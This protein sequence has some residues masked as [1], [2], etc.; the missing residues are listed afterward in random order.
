MLRRV[1]Q[2]TGRRRVD[3]LPQLWER[4]LRFGSRSRLLAAALLATLAAGQGLADVVHLLD[5]DRISGQVVSRRK[6]TLVVK[7]SF[8]SLTIPRAKIARIVR[9]D[10]SQE[11]LNAPAAPAAT[12]APPPPVR[13]VL[14]VTGQ[15][16]WYAWAPPKGVA[17]DP[18]LRLMVSLDEATI[19][20][21]TDAT[22]DPRDLPSALVNSFS[23][24]PDVVTLS[25]SGEAQVASPESRPGR[26]VLK[27]DLP[28]QMNRRHR[29]RLA[30]Q[31]NDG[32]EEEPAW[33]DCAE[34]A[35][36]IALR[37]DAPNFVHISQNRGEME[38]SGLL[39]RKMKRVES[40]RIQARPE[41]SLEEA[42][43]PS[44]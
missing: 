20:T 18:T 42:A 33:R 34:T 43:P 19:A 35:L 3:A 6:T 1:F 36:E 44:S 37:E 32:S 14:V 8:G 17:V 26:A 38:F 13:L 25:A 9:D 23:F 7:T 4:G 31:I 28:S 22:L 12:P 41:R 27:I 29:L 11:V 39:K 40:F 2:A 16:F 10:G 24:E 5:G 21:Y 15:A 30:Y